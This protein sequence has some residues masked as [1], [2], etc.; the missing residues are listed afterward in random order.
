MPTPPRGNNAKT[1]VIFWTSERGAVVSAR[2]VDGPPELQQAGLAAIFQW[3]F[4]PNS[5][6]GQPVQ[7]ASAVLFDFSHT[8]VAIQLTK[9]TAAQIAPDFEFQCWDGLAHDYPPSV[10]ICRQ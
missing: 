5:V 7:M 6:N 8:P 9:L 4:K 1:S 3:K 2:A 10:D